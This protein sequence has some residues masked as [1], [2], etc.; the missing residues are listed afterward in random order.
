MKL[1][2]EPPCL[3]FDPGQS[4]LDKGTT[5]ML[6]CYVPGLS[7]HGG[8]LFGK[9]SYYSWKYWWD[10]NLV[11]GS[12]MTISKVLVDSNLVVQYRIDI[13]VHLHV[14]CVYICE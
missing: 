14:H 13:H 2:P 10:S 11:V 9:L 8:T 4:D 1:T 3:I 7:S 5:Y 6:H 12:Q